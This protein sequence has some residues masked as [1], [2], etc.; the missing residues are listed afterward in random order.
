MALLGATEAALGVVEGLQEG[1]K[2]GEVVKVGI[3]FQVRWRD[4][5]LSGWKTCTSRTRKYGA[6]GDTFDA[7]GVTFEIID[8]EQA[9]LIYV[10]V[11]LHKKEGCST[12][13]EFKEVWKELHPRKG[14]DDSQKVWV[15]LFRRV[16]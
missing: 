12:P 7:F 9:E 11:G 4:R 15:H 5:M 8:V 3:P 13:W 1:E 6:P 10:A 2:G 16:Q 14:W